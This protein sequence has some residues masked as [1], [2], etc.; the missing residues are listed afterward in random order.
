ML[1]TLCP[2]AGLRLAVGVQWG[3]MLILPPL[4]ERRQFGP[5]RCLSFPTCKV[6]SLSFHGGCYQESAQS[7][8]PP[9]SDL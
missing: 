5:A 7:S 1:L 9:S 6:R 3:L 8:H 4:D 2:A